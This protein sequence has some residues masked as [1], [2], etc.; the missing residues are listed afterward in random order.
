MKK[1]IIIAILSVCIVLFAGCGAKTVHALEQ[2]ETVEETEVIATE[3]EQ[4]IEMTS[5]E[6]VETTV[7]DLDEEESS[8]E[9]D[10]VIVNGFEMVKHATADLDGDGI[11]EKITFDGKNLHVNDCVE[12]PSIDGVWR[13]EYDGN[14]S[15]VDYDKEDCYLEIMLPAEE[16]QDWINFYR[17][18]D[19]EIQTIGRLI[20]NYENEAFKVP[21]DGMVYATERMDVHETSYV[22]ATYVFD[23]NELVF[24]ES[25]DDYLYSTYEKHVCSLNEELTVYESKDRNSKVTIMKPQNVRFR[26]T[27]G[28]NWVE[29][30]AEDGTSGWMYVGEPYTITD[31]DNKDVTE[32]FTGTGYGG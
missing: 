7:T 14:F 3:T 10:A 28:K 23:G 25:E 20:E 29:V 4:E 24:L 16:I 6:T 9:A 26:S 30:V 5:T 2:A 19:G 12:D 22:Y 8:V 21:G 27:D 11:E 15:I 18:K 31:C 1:R 32:V 17:Y 13:F